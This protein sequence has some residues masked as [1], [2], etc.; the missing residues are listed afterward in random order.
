MA[1]IIDYDKTKQKAN[2]EK[3]MVVCPGEKMAVRI[4]GAAPRDGQ[5]TLRLQDSAGNDV[6]PAMRAQAHAGQEGLTF[7]MISDGGQKVLWRA[8]GLNLIVGAIGFVL[9]MLVF[10]ML[11]FGAVVTLGMG[12]ILML[13][14]TLRN[15]VSLFVLC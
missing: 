7:G 13:P 11:I 5:V 2:K 9:T 3:A 4:N 1:K 14:L 10:G 6:V 15:C 12:L 8:L